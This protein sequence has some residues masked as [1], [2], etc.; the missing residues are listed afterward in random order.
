MANFINTSIEISSDHLFKVLHIDKDYQAFYWIINNSGKIV[1]ALSEPQAIA[2]LETIEF[3]L[4][5]SEPQN[6]AIVK[7]ERL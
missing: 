3:D 2:L 1:S 4:I 5:F 6:L 7:E